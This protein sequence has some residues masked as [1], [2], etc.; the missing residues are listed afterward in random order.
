MIR[1]S[2]VSGGY[3]YSDGYGWAQGWQIWIESGRY[4]IYFKMARERGRRVLL[5]CFCLF[6]NVTGSNCN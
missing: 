6:D 3:G 2:M 5:Y 1:I 4:G